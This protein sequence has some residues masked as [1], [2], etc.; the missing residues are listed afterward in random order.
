MH[1]N[2]DDCNILRGARIVMNGLK[3]SKS[4]VAE[5]RRF[6]WG[7]ESLTRTRSGVRV[8]TGLPLNRE[9]N[10]PSAKKQQKT[11]RIHS[12]ARLR[13]PVP[14]RHLGLHLDDHSRRETRNFRQPIT[15][16]DYRIAQADFPMRIG[17]VFSNEDER[18][19]YD[20]RFEDYQV[21]GLSAELQ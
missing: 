8:P 11:R 18:Q 2:A 1:E 17:Q 3:M 16:R 21:P 12:R 7:T 5:N 4:Y 9:M 13:V 6:R 20:S 15:T 14:G 19:L 10:Y